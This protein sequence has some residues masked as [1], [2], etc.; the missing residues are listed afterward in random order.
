M[1]TLGCPRCDGGLDWGQH[2]RS[3]FK[4]THKKSMGSEAKPWMQSMDSKAKAWM[5]SDALGVTVA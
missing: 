1:D 5:P 4:E 2:E 3:E